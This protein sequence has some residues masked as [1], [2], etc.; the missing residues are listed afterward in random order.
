MSNHDEDRLSR[1]LHDRAGDVH[2]APVD[3]ADV[4]RS[5]RVIQRRR[6]TLAAVAAVAVVEVVAVGLNLTGPPDAGRTVAPAT[7]S[8]SASASSTP[9][10]AVS[11][12]PPPASPSVPQVEGVTPLTAKG[13]PSGAP[14]TISYLRG[15]T[16]VVPGA[17][18]VRLPAA[19][20]TVAPYQGG[21][22]AVQRKQG[23]AYVVHVDASGQVTGSR[24]G[25]DRIVTSQD[26]I[27]VAW[28]ED[29]RLLLDTTNG[30]SDTPPASLD[31]PKGIVSA[32]PV[33]FVGPG[34][35][36]VSVTDEA[37]QQYYV[38]DLRT[39][40]P[41]QG[42]VLG[43]RATDE[44]RG[45]VGVQR[46]YNNNGTSCWAVATNRPGGSEP[47]TCDWTLETFAVD[48]LHVAGYPSGVD[49]L[50]S[51]TVALLDTGTLK[52]VV[53]FDRQ[54]DGVTLVADTVW[55]D[56]SHVLASLYDGDA[57][58]LVRLGLDGSLE[59]L[60]EASGA[61]ED[62]PFRFVAHS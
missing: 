14:A 43:V 35:V 3:L 26:G 5:A 52:R 31:L 54:G 44:G 57:W 23:T 33:G 27:E 22:L 30:H 53:T 61:P 47:R 10:T 16:L 20:D 19:Y 29:G 6:R 62:S 17:D 28:I 40:A 55:E 13:A 11:P 36:V 38:S 34:S 41:L 59:K 56:E 2:G 50:G 60:D 21:W 8:Q 45:V 4:R 1:S 9:S 58:Y 51:S 24:P 39:L 46:S 15:R 42:D 48:G 32:H 25:G 12:T 37:T 18:P 49:G 7:T